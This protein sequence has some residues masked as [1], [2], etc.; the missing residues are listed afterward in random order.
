MPYIFL[1]IT[2]IPFF[3]FKSEYTIDDN[4]MFSGAYPVRHFISWSVMR[5]RTH[6]SRNVI[7]AVTV[8]FCNFTAPHVWSLFNLFMLLIT[9]KLFSYIFFNN[10]RQSLWLSALAFQFI[11]AAM[12][13]ETGT[14]TIAACYL[15]TFTLSLAVFVPFR[16]WFK[17]G[18]VP[19]LPVIL[20]YLALFYAG[21]ME[22]YLLMIM[23]V[24][25]LI[26]AW[27]I[28]TGRR[29]QGFMAG[30]IVIAAFQLIWFL[31]CP[32]NR[33]RAGAGYTG[34]SV[35]YRIIKGFLSYSIYY[36]NDIGFQFIFALLLTMYL[37][38]Y[39]KYVKN[40]GIRGAFA[41]VSVILIL[42]SLV[43]SYLWYIA[44]VP[45]KLRFLFNMQPLST[46]RITLPEY[47][48]ETVLYLFILA[49]V[50]VIPFLADS[51]AEFY[52]TVVRRMKAR[53]YVDCGNEAHSKNYSEDIKNIHDNQVEQNFQDFQNFQNYQG[54]QAV[55]G[56]QDKQ[57][58]QS[59]QDNQNRQGIKSSLDIQNKQGVPDN[60][61]K[62]VAHN[63]QDNNLSPDRV[64]I[65]IRRIITINGKYIVGLE[66]LLAVF[67]RMVFGFSPSVFP[68][69]H[70]LS[71][72]STMGF[73]AAI[74]TMINFYGNRFKYTERIFTVVA[75]LSFLKNAITIIME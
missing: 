15:W 44:A 29:F 73:A 57:V 53:R 23:V 60:Q 9:L 18:R 33:V 62:K 4:N 22:N 8:F 52:V 58:V 71:F 7:E 41:G 37:C 14:V 38:I 27:M 6:T 12:L 30:Y 43:S 26:F 32:G 24:L 39:F 13:T 2:Y 40:K 46:S 55:Q 64:H 50:T 16:M 68:Y 34:K 11:P 31:T 45:K 5:Y 48:A 66:I 54:K 70:R 19:A 56:S 63:S 42:F 49:W 20:S 75:L 35:I 51:D 25:I 67:S 65:K 61:G 1:A 3:L 21:N 36:F 47:A 74:I 10:D 59:S 72:I 28:F 17:D 69:A